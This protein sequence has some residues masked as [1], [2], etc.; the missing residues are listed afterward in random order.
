VKSQWRFIVVVILLGCTAL[1]LHA[2]NSSE[3]IPDRLQLSSFPK[4]FP[5]W[6]SS[7]I[8]ISKDVLDVLGPGDFLLRDYR[9]QADVSSVDLFIAYFPSQR[10]GDTIHS[11]KNCL[12][13]A[14]WTPLQSERITIR[15]PGMASFPANRY[16]IVKGQ[17]RQ[18]V[19][20]SYWAH[21]RVVASEYWAKFYLV[22]DSIQMHRT[23]GSL[24]RLNTYLG[25][26][27]SIES[28][29]RRLLSL[30]VNVVPRIPEYVP[31]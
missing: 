16:L 11:P 10:A 12:P 23:D 25:K 30:A 13:G 20:Y 4:E 27:E 28:G 18:L 15:L 7:D 31:R 3:I 29:E 6:I 5:G 1:L 8:P 2:R 17:D 19:L 26:D 24:V 9:S 14:G 22:K 21:N